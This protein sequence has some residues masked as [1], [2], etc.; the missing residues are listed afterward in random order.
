M[1]VLTVIVILIAIVSITVTMS[2][3]N[4][5]SLQSRME[6]ENEQRIMF[7][8][9]DDRCK[10]CNESGNCMFSEVSSK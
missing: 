1:E 7:N 4:V 9:C 3:M 8:Y 5:S 6:E 2:F 10:D